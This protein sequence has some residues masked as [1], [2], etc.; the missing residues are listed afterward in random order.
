PLPAS[1][2]GLGGGVGLPHREAPMPVLLVVGG[3]LFGS[4]AAAYAR[5]QGIEALVFDAGLDG[6]A[7]PAAAGL[8]REA[9]AGKKL[10]EHFHHALPLLARLCGI[11]VVTL[12]RD[13]GGAE[14][15][16]W[17]PPAEVLEPAPLR[18]RVSAVGDG[19]VEAEGRRHDGWVY[20]AA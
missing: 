12:T 16:L 5:S 9:W 17:V 7:S 19:W 14:S 2:R 15:L 13:D 11:R 20:V 10:R 3:G 1:G 18:Q 6:A 8:F 4:L